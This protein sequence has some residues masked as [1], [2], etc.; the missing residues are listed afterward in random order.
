MSGQAAF[1]GERHRH[2]QRLQHAF[3]VGYALPG[4][5]EGGAVVHGRSNEGQP[6]VHADALG[7]VVDLDR[8]VPLVVVH[9]ED[10]VVLPVNGMVEAGLMP[11]GKHNNKKLIEIL[12]T[13]LDGLIAKINPDIII[14]LSSKGKIN[15]CKKIT[16]SAFQSGSI[17]ITGANSIEQIIQSF[18]FI[19][20]IYD[21]VINLKFSF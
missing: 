1:A 12:N 9:S 10:H 13:D 18:N 11:Y 8:Y 20:T 19:N 4:D 21:H 17:I 3:M 16:I 6:E 7:P 14:G 5:V 2:F 15:N